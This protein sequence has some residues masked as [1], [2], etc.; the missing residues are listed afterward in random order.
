ML[1]MSSSS[2]TLPTIRLDATL[3][4]LYGW[5]SPRLADKKI[6]QLLC[7]ISAAMPL[8][9]DVPRNLK[10][11][12]HDASFTRPALDDKSDAAKLRD[13]FISGDTSVL[14]FYIGSDKDQKAHD[15]AEADRTMAVLDRTQ[16]PELL[17]CPGPSELPIKDANIDLVAYKIALDDL[18]KYNL[19]IPAETHWFL[20][21][22][23]ALARSGLPTPRCT[24]IELDGFSSKADSCCDS[25]RESHDPISIPLN[26]AGVRGMWL[27]EQ[28]QKVY[29]VLSGYPVPFVLKN[30][31]TFGGAG[32][33]LIRTEDD[34]QALL[35]DFRGGV[36]SHLLATV[37]EHNHHLSPGNLLFSD[38]VTEP[39]GDYGVTFFVADDEKEP[40]FLAASEQLTDD[41]NAWIGST[42]NYD[43]QEEL[44]RKFGPLIKKIAEW[45]QGY[46]YV[47]PCGADILETASKADESNGADGT[48]EEHWP[49]FHV[50]DLNV[51]TSGSLCLPLLGGHFTSRGLQS[52]SS[53][54]ISVRKDR[55]DFIALFP[56]EFEDGSMAILSWYRDP[57]TG[58]SLADVAVGAKDARKLKEEMQRVRDST[59][60]VTF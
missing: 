52:A 30:Q 3:S 7:G 39:I 4:E 20:N 43:R 41:D 27:A 34:R 1:M 38:F 47:G 54:S 24:V 21:S 44:K 50:V 31:Q 59:D 22:K 14:L 42:I 36:L 28:S 35:D 33:Y 29:D 8:S 17:F 10:Y 13:A 49:N 25:C 19:L 51:R 15:K 5:A 58:V 2:P 45:L 26:C 40:M 16:Q 37:T 53:F 18:D 57:R 6:A 55:D 56:T 60:Q 46:G 32:T 12:Y 48:G 9:K 11:L 23:E